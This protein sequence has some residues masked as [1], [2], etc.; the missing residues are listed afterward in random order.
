MESDFQHNNNMC[1]PHK[2]QELCLLCCTTPGVTSDP[3][4][5]LPGVVQSVLLTPYQ[6]K[7]KHGTMGRLPSVGT[8]DMCI[9]NLDYGTYKNN[10]YQ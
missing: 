7:N 4:A 1:D 8:L 5:L 2:H 6:I 10:N 3:H 9:F